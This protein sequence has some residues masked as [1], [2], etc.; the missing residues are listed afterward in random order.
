MPRQA[1]HP[2]GRNYAKSELCALRNRSKQPHRGGEGGARAARLLPAG[3]GSVEGAADCLFLPKL[4][5]SAFEAP[6]LFEAGHD[7]HHL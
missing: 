1:R 3:V 7:R 2:L 5:V 4:C 6:I